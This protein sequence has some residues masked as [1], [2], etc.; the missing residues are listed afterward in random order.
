METIKSK[1]L[2]VLIGDDRTGKTTIQKLLINKLTDKGLYIKLPVNV[3]ADITH[4]EIKRK[5]QTISFANRSYQEK[6]SEYGTV[7]EYFKNHFKDTDIAF[8]S[9]HLVLSDIKKM[10][11]NGRRRF[12]NVNG[13]F[14]TNSI[15][16]NPSDNADIAA[17]DWNERFIIFNSLSDDEETIN[18]QLEL[19]ADSIVTLLINR[20][21]IS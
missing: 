14:W 20:T 6:Q 3:D 21:H 8:I 19:I 10:I 7:D 2:F 5:Y 15:E 13:V 18:A 16:D 9:S 12:Y 11:K 4:L 17:L 1:Q